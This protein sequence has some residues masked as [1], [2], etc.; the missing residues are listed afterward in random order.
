MVFSP[1]LSFCSHMRF[2]GMS[3]CVGRIEINILTPDSW[4]PSA[5]AGCYHWSMFPQA[6]FAYARIISGL[7][8][9]YVGCL[10]DCPV[11]VVAGSWTGCRRWKWSPVLRDTEASTWRFIAISTPQTAQINNWLHSILVSHIW[12]HQH[13]QTLWPAYQLE[14]HEPLHPQQARDLSDYWRHGHGQV[15]VV[16]LRGG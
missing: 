15:G 16:S 7:H 3:S 14:C 8:D 2:S 12:I 5:P 6:S 1:G 11:N 4:T 9:C 10:P 13:P